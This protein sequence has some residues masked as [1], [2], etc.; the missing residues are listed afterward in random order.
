MKTKVFMSVRT[1]GGNQKRQI[2]R[3]RK[4]K[5]VSQPSDEGFVKDEPQLAVEDK[6]L[7]AINQL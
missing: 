2:V 1:E 7:E 6:E 5:V 4:I 3:R